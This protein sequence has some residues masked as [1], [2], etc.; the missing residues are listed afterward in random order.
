MASCVTLDRVRR[1]VD[2]WKWC[3]PQGSKNGDGAMFSATEKGSFG[4]APTHEDK[5]G[6]GSITVEECCPEHSEFSLRTSEEHCFWT[7]TLEIKTL[8][9][10]CLCKSPKNLKA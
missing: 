5:Y 3:W 7:D 4:E 6:G 8:F 10:G 2:V 1:G 9:T